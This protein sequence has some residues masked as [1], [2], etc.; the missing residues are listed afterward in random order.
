M[1]KI[2][3]GHFQPNGS[4]NTG[5]IRSPFLQGDTIHDSENGLIMA[6]H[7]QLYNSP[8]N[9]TINSR[10][11]TKLY[12]L[13]R[14]SGLAGFDGAFILVVFDQKA[15]TLTI[16]RDKAGIQRIYYSIINEE[17]WFSDDLAILAK[18]VPL[19]KQISSTAL[20]QY[21]Q[22]AYIPTPLTI[23]EGIYTL[24]AG[25]YLK[26][27]PSGIKF[28]QYWDPEL[29]QCDSILNEMGYMKCLR[30]TL[31]D[32]V[33]TRLVCEDTMG[34]LLSGGI[35]STII[36]GLA[37]MMT[38]KL[39]S[40]TIGFKEAQFDESE[41]AQAA[42]AF[43]NTIHHMMK[44]DIKNVTSELDNIIESMAQP[45]ADSS[46]IPSYFANKFA[47]DFVKDVLTG[48][49]SDQLFAGSS[50][51]AI[52]YF[53]D[54]YLKIPKRIRKTIIER[55]LDNISDTSPLTRK[56]KKVIDSAGM[57]QWERYQVVL[58]LAF[59][60]SE[61]Q[62]L[63]IKYYNANSL[64]LIHE[65]YSKHKDTQDELARMLYTD[66]KV[67]VE[68]DMLVKMTSM[69]RLAGIKTHFPMVSS[70]MLDLSFRIPSC[71]KMKGKSGKIILKRTFDD[72]IPHRLKKAPKSG[73]TIPL[74]VW[75]REKPEYISF[76][77]FEEDI[78]K[79]QG[80][81]NPDYVTKIRREHITK[82]VNRK[83]ELWALYIFQRWYEINFGF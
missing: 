11:I 28:K 75:F 22:L 62:Q 40:F 42:A 2:I 29:L 76:A 25:H 23:Y 54:K 34:V 64:S 45:F 51:Y 17:L 41:R 9:S 81:F 31:T 78:L 82:K 53:A 43:H 80:I 1:T 47:S 50:R 71:Y 20:C 19:S 58:S 6:F 61:L 74:D 79:K 39:H 35:D 44:L 36:T 38:S 18:S 55:L 33:K 72:L 13:K 49:A 10:T 21:F 83:I 46:A 30:D 67:A 65:I 52:H 56:I 26:L 37:S 8:S 14:E 69:S 5:I 68:G 63:L 77:F 48:D 12:A 3:L 59:M 32:S 27:G 60:D 66:F 15:N 24:P 73:F 4:T 70:N 57:D 7:G 16:A